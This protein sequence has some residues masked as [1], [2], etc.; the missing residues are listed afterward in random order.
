MHITELRAC[1][2]SGEEALRTGIQIKIAETEADFEKIHR[3]NY[4]TFAEEI[5]QHEKNED[6]RL[7]DRFHAENTY[8]IALDG[9]TLAGMMAVRGKRPFSLDE[10][11]KELGN[12]LPASRRVCEIR[13][14]SVEKEYR[15]GPAFF[16]LMKRV[17]EYCAEQGYDYA[18]I[19]G[20]TRQQKLY[21]H[22]GFRPFYPQL[23]KP[24]AYYIPMGASLE[25]FRGRLGSL[26]HK[27]KG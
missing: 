12:Y 15:G 20:T 9:E 10:K 7:V 23:G 11:I 21:R 26:P 2:S 8:I 24:G 4:R 3:L 18:V 14:L 19:S 5:P 17:S 1:C 6:G 13:L 22:L 27:E 16:L 25:D